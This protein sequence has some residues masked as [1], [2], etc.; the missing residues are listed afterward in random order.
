MGL[1]E[2]QRKRHFNRTPEPSGASATPAPE[3]ERSFVIQ[4][5]HASVRHYDFRLEIDGV[6]RSWSIPKGPSLRPGDRRLAVEVE[7]HPLDYADFSGQIP[8]GEYGAGHVAIFDAG[9]WVPEGDP[10]DAIARGKLEFQLF[11]ERLRGRWNLIRTRRDA[12]KPQW[13]LI[14]RTDEHAADLEADD[15]LDGIPEPPAASPGASTERGRQIRAAHADANPESSKAPGVK[16]RKAP[17]KTVAKSSSGTEASAR[18]A[19]AKE[20]GAAGTKRRARA[21]TSGSD[22]TLDALRERARKL[23]DGRRIESVE[24]AEP[25][26]TIAADE[27]PAGEDWVHEWKWDGYRVVAYASDEPQLWSRNGLSWTARVPEIVQAL[28]ALGIE[29][30]LDGELIAVDENGY[31]TFNGLQQALKDG[32]TSQLRY[33]VFDLMSLDG[34]DLR[35][36]PLVERKALLQELLD[37]A[38]ARL[39]FST[40]VRGQGPELFEAAR[41]RGME[42]IISKRADSTYVSGRSSHWL[43]VKAVETRDFIVVGW[44]DPKG[45]RKGLGALLLAQRTGGELVYAGRVGSGLGAQML[46]DLPRRLRRLA[47]DTPPVTLP[48][49]LPRPAG[50]VQ[51]VRPELVVEVI[52]R[53]WSKEGLL[54]QAT[55]HRLRD[56]KPADEDTAGDRPDAA[57]PGSKAAKRASPEPADARPAATKAPRKQPSR[58]KAKDADEDALPTLS[59]PTRVVYPDAGYTKQAVCDYYLSVADRLLPEISGRLLSIVRCPEGIDGQRFFQKHAGRGFGDAVH[60]HTIVESSGEEAGYFYVDSVAGLMQLVQMN[61]IEFHPWG[62]TVDALE[63]PDR[64]VFDLDPDPGVPWTRVKQAAVEVRDRLEEVGLASYPKLTGGKGVHVVAPLAPKAEWEQVRVFCEAFADAM[65]RQ[66]PKRFV[67]T[68]S[69]AKREDR[70]FIDWLRNGRG[71]TSVASWSLRARAGAPAA[72]PLTWDELA[73]ERKAAR[74]TLADAGSRELPSLVEELVARQQT[75]PLQ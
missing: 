6:L 44:S 74:V 9:C 20:A 62:S 48:G 59:S 23:A 56:D 64:I 60:R 27:A 15:L 52:F 8:K 10:A 16:K 63:R 7:D 54:R 70:I 11:G 61:T 41:A 21:S 32:E 38:D 65:V 51:W 50:Q 67:A 4:L 2:Y 35:E 5:H 55:F 49:H 28:G 40:H 33:C 29:A 53:G 42:G 66:A 26:L 71:A 30:E 19:P 45:S 58:S 37:G 47:T 24:F 36:A 75:L 69:K 18:K 3:G 22:K 14:K 31:S 43:K 25:M 34:H 68:M 1:T 12:S 39:F 13:L 57:V 72:V 73:S 17:S 46:R